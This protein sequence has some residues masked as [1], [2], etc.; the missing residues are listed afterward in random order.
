[1]GL[2]YGF[3]RACNICGSVARCGLGRVVAEASRLWDT[4]MIELKS[5]TLLTVTHVLASVNSH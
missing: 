2:R 5:Y 4:T 1:M 3:S